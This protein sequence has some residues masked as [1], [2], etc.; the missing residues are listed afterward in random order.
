MGKSCCSGER[1]LQ[2]IVDLLLGCHDFDA[3]AWGGEHAAPDGSRVGV[4]VGVG[5]GVG[6]AVHSRA[7][8]SVR[9]SARTRPNQT[10]SRRDNGNAY[11]LDKRCVF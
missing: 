3:M 4:G 10:R 6:V 11:A 8:A 2:H 5:A 9:R 1:L 7:W